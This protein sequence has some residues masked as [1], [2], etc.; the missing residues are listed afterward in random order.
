[1]SG[2]K[3]CYSKKKC[4]ERIGTHRSTYVRY[5]K[6]G[7]PPRGSD[8]QKGVQA[9]TEPKRR[10]RTDTDTRT[11]TALTLTTQSKTHAQIATYL[12]TIDSPT[13]PSVV[14]IAN[15]VSY[16]RALVFPALPLRS[17]CWH[18]PPSGA[19]PWLVGDT[20]TQP[21]APT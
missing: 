17:E 4:Y 11:H 16:I 6:G 3:G 10:I 19:P 2:R 5:Q 18:K 21:Y 9:P 7:V 8:N 20:P 15:G 14:F 1:M 12:L 13:L